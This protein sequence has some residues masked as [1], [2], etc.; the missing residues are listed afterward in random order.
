[1]RPKIG[2]GIVNRAFAL[3]ACG[4]AGY[5]GASALLAARRWG[6]PPDVRR[7]HQPGLTFFKPLKPGDPGA[8]GRIADLLEIIGP[9]DD[10]VAGV[11]ATDGCARRA[12][13]R[14]AA[15]SGGRLAFIG[16]PD[17]SRGVNPKIAKLLQMEN[18]GRNRL[19]VVT[20]SEVIPE[21]QWIEELRTLLD[22][23]P[24]VLVTAAYRFCGMQ[25]SAEE[26]DAAAN[27]LFLWPGVALRAEFGRADF[28]FGALLACDRT[29]LNALG[30]WQRVST[31]LADDY[32]L[33]QTF[34]RAGRPIVIARSIVTLMSDRLTPADVWRHQ[35]RVARTYREAS[36]AGFAGSIFVNALVAFAAAWIAFP[37]RRW[38]SLAALL[39]A[40]SLA[41]RVVAKAFGESNRVWQ[42]GVVVT[43]S[44]VEAVA[45][46]ASWLPLPVEWGGARHTVRRGKLL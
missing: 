6:T 35:L 2:Y 28:A 13:E 45:W 33:A 36:P 30:G 25:T 37:G 22:E 5:W 11:S 3:V 7:A 15:V 4:A 41:R 46:V 16:C 43:G 18:E 19:I 24:D 29:V 40:R 21:T 20:D 31:H 27:G 1:M 12:L 14:L 42:P 38:T 32:A 17:S 9:L 8:V 34:R 44:L 39:V 23:T 26:M 10:V